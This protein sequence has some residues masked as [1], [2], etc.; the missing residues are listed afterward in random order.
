MWASPAWQISNLVVVAMHPWPV[1]TEEK[2]CMDAPFTAQGRNLV[3][4]H[5]TLDTGGYLGFTSALLAD[6]YVNKVN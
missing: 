4:H 1:S 6:R 5:L 2:W 3:D